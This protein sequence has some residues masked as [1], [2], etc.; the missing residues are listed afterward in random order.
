M[1]AILTITGTLLTLAPINPQAIRNARTL[2]DPNTLTDQDPDITTDLALINRITTW[3]PHWQNA[4]AD[5]LNQNQIAIDHAEDRLLTAYGYPVPTAAQQYATRMKT[6]DT[7][8]VIHDAAEAAHPISGCSKCRA[9]EDCP[10]ADR[11]LVDA[12]HADWV[13]RWNTCL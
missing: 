10:A 6:A 11:A 13:T 3:L 9:W 7:T 5:T 8:Q 1:N 2:I 4:G 12:V